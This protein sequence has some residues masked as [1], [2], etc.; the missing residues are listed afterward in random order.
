LHLLKQGAS[1]D[2]HAGGAVPDL[3]VLALGELHQQLADLV[4]HL[5]LLQDGRAIVRCTM[6][7]ASTA[8]HQT[9]AED[10]LMNL[11]V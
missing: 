7:C 1:H 4:L 3:V 10:S 5:H 11:R 8:S 2:H 6:V 9:R